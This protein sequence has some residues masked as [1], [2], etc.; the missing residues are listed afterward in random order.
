MNEPIDPKAP[1]FRTYDESKTR[2]ELQIKI[3]QAIS[4]GKKRVS[5]LKT[6]EAPLMLTKVKGEDKEES[7]NE[8]EE[9]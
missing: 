9:S 5:K 7:K 8:E 6:V 2:I 4:R 1:I 3:P